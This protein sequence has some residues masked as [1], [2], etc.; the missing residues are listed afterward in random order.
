MAI[1][2]HLDTDNNPVQKTN[3]LLCEINLERFKLLLFIVSNVHV[4]G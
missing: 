3:F 2:E 4:T 1:T